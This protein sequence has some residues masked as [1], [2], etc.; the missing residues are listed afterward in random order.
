MN[1]GIQAS[2][3][4][5]ESQDKPPKEVEISAFANALMELNTPQAIEDTLN[6]NITNYAFRPFLT[7]KAFLW[8]DL[9]HRF[10]RVGGGGTRRRPEIGKAYTDENTIGFALSHSPKD[11]KDS[12]KPFASFCWYHPDNDLCRRG[13]SFVYLNQYPTSRNSNALA[14]NINSELC[15]HLSTLL[16]LSEAALTSEMVFY[17]YAILCSQ[18]YLD[19]FEGALFTVNRADMRPRIPIVDDAETFL[20]LSALGRKIAELEKNYYTPRNIAGYDYDAIKAELPDGFKLS[21]SKAVQPFNE[22][23]ETITLTDGRINITIYC[24]LEIQRLNIGGYEVIKNTWLKFNSYDFTHCDFTADDIVGLLN[25]VNKLLEY[26]ELVG[27]VDVAVHEI[28][29]IITSRSMKR[30]SGK[31]LRLQNNSPIT[32]KCLAR[33]LRALK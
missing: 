10:S 31:F 14:S 28:S 30:S 17:V 25:L 27:E 11:Q 20:R 16:K 12:L 19:E 21:W 9:L 15:E 24:P 3:E 22:D 1:R 7:M 6:K 5:L 26:I 23:E 2:N 13:N 8:Q 29:L 4:W 18:V 33:K 32:K